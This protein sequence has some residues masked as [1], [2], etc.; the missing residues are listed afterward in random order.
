[1]QQEQTM[2][3]ITVNINN[4]QLAEKKD[5]LEII[6]KEDMEDLKLLKAIRGEE[7]ISFAEFLKNGN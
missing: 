4:D 6:S 7:S 5:G 1:M 2:H 3:T